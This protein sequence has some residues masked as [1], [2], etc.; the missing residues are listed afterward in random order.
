MAST[1]VLVPVHRQ[2]LP[3]NEALAMRYSLAAL[4]R[5]EICFIAPE[6]L[7]VSEYRRDF[8]AARWRFFDARYFTSTDAYSTLLLSPD[9]YRAFADHSHMLIVQ[10]DC[11]VLRD[12]LDV[13]MDSPYDYVGAP[14]AEPWE[15]SL[16]GL[17]TPFDE[18]KFSVMVGNGGLSLRRPAA[19]LR[20]LDELSWL[21]ARFQLIVEDAFFSLAGHISA[22]FIVP[23]AVCAARFSIEREPRRYVKIAGGLPMGVHAWERYDKPFWLEQFAQLN[24]TRFQ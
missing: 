3:F 16:A 15:Y 18:L 10:P 9:F 8:P 21:T 12:D 14:W 23:N 19:A 24:L 17:G 11:M 2:S 20:V 13:W 4:W 5:R 1:V 7:D 22:N 6:G